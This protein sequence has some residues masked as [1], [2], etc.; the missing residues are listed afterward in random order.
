MVVSGHS[1]SLQLTGLGKSFPLICEQQSKLNYKRRL[2]SVY[3]QGAPGVPSLDD[4]GGYATPLYRL[5]TMLS[6]IHISEPTRH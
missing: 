6:L 3:K 5:P 4:R 1:Q 2:Y